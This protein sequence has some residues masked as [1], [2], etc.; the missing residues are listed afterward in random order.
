MTDHSFYIDNDIE[1][2][3]QKVENFISIFSLPSDVPSEEMPKFLADNFH[4]AT[5]VH[6]QELESELT[7]TLLNNAR[8]NISAST[9]KELM[10]RNLNFVNLVFEELSKHIQKTLFYQDKLFKIMSKLTVAVEKNNKAAAAKTNYI[11]DDLYAEFRSFK[12]KIFD[13]TCE[14]EAK[15]DRK[16][17]KQQKEQE[18]SSVKSDESQLRRLIDGSLM[19]IVELKNGLNKLNS[20]YSSEVK[21]TSVVV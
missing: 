16:N 2:R 4:L 7:S 8:N 12:A 10:K 18:K 19:E 13:L 6:L 21:E 9:V 20:K 3:L 14:I 1:K 17:E 5:Q 15:I 11:R